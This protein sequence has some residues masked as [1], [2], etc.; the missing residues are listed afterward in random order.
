MILNKLIEYAK[1]CAKQHNLVLLDFGMGDTL[2]YTKIGFLDKVFIGLT[3]TPKKEGD[4]FNCE[5]VDL[6]DIL[7]KGKYFDVA[8]RAQALSAINAIGQFLSSYENIDLQGNL[9]E[10]LTDFINHKSSK[11]DKIV[12]IGNLSP[13]VLRLKQH[14]KDVNV[15]C[16]QESDKHLGVYNDIFEYEGVSQAD[17]VVITGAS[18]I[19][20]T[21]DALLKFTQKARIVILAGFSAGSYPK[22]YSNLGIT[23]VASINTNGFKICN[24]TT[25]EDIFERKCYL[26][27]VSN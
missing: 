20:S 10:V 22:W 5:Y 24:N 14:G 8:K 4:L 19:G 2:T 16:R 25:L 11:T 15:F 6:E 18:L 23:H 3:I 27:E 26:V 1:I 9:R 17:I 7:N 12:F 21:I 13:V